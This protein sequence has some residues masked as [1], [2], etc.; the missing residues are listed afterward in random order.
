LDTIHVTA[1]RS[2]TIEIASERESKAVMLSDFG[3][4]LWIFGVFP[5]FVL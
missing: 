4:L 3:F 5:L 2:D 1:G